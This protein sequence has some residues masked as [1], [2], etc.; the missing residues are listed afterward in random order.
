MVSERLDQE[1]GD[2]M[3]MTGAHAMGEGHPPLEG[4]PK[5]H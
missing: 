4:H 1:L 3:N 5:R 2:S